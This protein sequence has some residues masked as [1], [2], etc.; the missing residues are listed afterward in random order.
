[1]KPK[2]NL[3]PTAS[4]VGEVVANGTVEIGVAPVSEILPVKGVDLV[5]PFPTEIQSYVEMTAAV[6][7]RPKRKG[8]AQGASSTS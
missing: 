8:A 2:Y 5:G 1:M 4:Q 3:R 6:S 7:A